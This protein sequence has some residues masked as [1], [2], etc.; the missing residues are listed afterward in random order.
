MQLDLPWLD[1]TGAL[2]AK[3][4]RQPQ[5]SRRLSRLGTDGTKNDLAVRIALSRPSRMRRKERAEFFALL[6]R[7]PTPLAQPELGGHEQL[8]GKM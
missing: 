3:V 4:V 7:A 1:G 2:M 5:L 8:F 6:G